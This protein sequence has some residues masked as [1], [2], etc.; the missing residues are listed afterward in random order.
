[1]AG[2]STSMRSGSGRLELALGSGALALGERRET[3]ALAGVLALAGMVAAL[4]GAL[5]LAGV[6]ADAVPFVSRIGRRRHGRTRQEKGGGGGG[7]SSTRLRSKFH[8]IPPKGCWQRCT[9][10]R[11]RKNSPDVQTCI[12]R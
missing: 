3:L 6:G 9:D 7:D 8:D 5:A 10:C 2:P 11:P 4:A 1:M 12:Q